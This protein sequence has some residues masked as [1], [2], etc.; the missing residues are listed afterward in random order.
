MAY[1]PDV[2]LWLGLWLLVWVNV[3]INRHGLRCNVVRQIYN[4]NCKQMW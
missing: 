1:I 4:W 3:R 2:S